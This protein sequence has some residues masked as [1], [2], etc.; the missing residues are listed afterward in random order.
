MMPFSCPAQD[1]CGACTLSAASASEPLSAKR[2]QVVKAFKKVGMKINVRPLVGM[3]DSF[4]YRNK[5]I[6]QV[7]LRAGKT[8]LALYEENSHRPVPVHD[9]LL[10]DTRLNAVLEDIRMLLDRLKIRPD[11]CGGV[12]KS[13]LLRIGVRTGQVMVVFVTSEEMFHGRGELVKKLVALHPEIRTVVQNTNPRRTSVILGERE[14][15]LYGTGFIYDELLGKRFKISPRSFYQ[16]NSVQTEKLYSKAIEL[17]SDPGT[18]GVLLDAYCGTGTIGLSAAT[19]F[20]RV[21]G[22]EINE[23]AVRDAKVNARINDVHNAL[24]CCD[25]A[26]FFMRE[27]DF[28]PDVLMIDPPRSGC[29]RDFLSSVLK[30]RPQRIVYISCC[31]ETQARDIAVLSRA[32]GCSDAYPFDMFPYT[33]HVEN[34]VS[35]QLIP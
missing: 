35:L 24:F 7:A 28:R 17:A 3:E 13:I 20:D 30:L 12:L 25:D 23:D 8:V 14:R 27:L 21:I 5:L 34:I 4:H 18:R 32:Y 1:L 26:K 2:E 11:G 31:P 29:D 10:H 9:C 15:V 19:H 16:I 22:V 6:V 33:A